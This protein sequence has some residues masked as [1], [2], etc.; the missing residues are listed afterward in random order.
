MAKKPITF[1]GKKRFAAGG[2]TDRAQSRFERRT[3]DIERDLERQISAA[4]NDPRRLN[5]ARAKYEQRMADARDDRA[6]RLGEDRTATRAAERT[7]ERALTRT[8]R[9]GERTAPNP[10]RVTSAEITAGNRAPTPISVADITPNAP[11]LRGSSNRDAMRF[12]EAFASARRE[13]VPTFTWKGKSYTTEVAGSGRTSPSRRTS[14]GA[15]GT[16][17]TPPPAAPRTAPPAAPRTP[18][19]A[20]A[21]IP[22][23]VRTVQSEA[24]LARALSGTN[25]PRRAPPGAAE[26]RAQLAARSEA[27]RRRRESEGAA[28]GGKVKRM[29]KGGSV[30]KS[31]DGIAK[32]GK[33]RAPKRNK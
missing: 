3:A 1:G 28:K 2:S 4:R 33:T 29:A 18:P 9:T 14:G 25:V 12:G 19:P 17:R 21:D 10:N 13:G 5:V 23:S 32:R 30:K 24:E 31:I 16:P 7:A 8:R 22:R 27:N 11:N 20:A 26:L 6:K 15:G